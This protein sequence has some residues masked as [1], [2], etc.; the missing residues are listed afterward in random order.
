MGQNHCDHE[1]VV[2]TTITDDEMIMVQCINCLT[3]GSVHSPSPDEFNEAFGAPSRPYRWEDETRVTEHHGE[4]RVPYV[5]RADNT[6]PICDCRPHER[7]LPYLRCPGEVLKEPAPMT[8]E[9]M[10]DLSSL[11]GAVANSNTCGTVLAAF[12][13]H[14]EDDGHEPCGAT[15]RIAAYME[16]VSKKGMHFPPQVVAF[17]LRKYAALG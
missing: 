7:H 15:K 12:L 11:A 3:I 9:E 2:F 13:R 17:V 5:I 8:P 16:Q 6:S 14:C 10:A 4:D 1:W